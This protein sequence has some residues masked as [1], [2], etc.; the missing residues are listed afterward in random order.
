MSYRRMIQSV[1]THSGEPMRVITGGVPHIPGDSV[2]EQAKWLERHDDQLRLMMLREPRGYPPLCCNLLVPPK[3]P[4]ADAGFIIMEQVEYPMMSGGNTIAVATVLLET[5]MIPMREPLTRFTLEAPAGLIDITAECRGG[6]VL[7]V[8]FENVPAFCAYRDAVL[9]VPELGRVTVDVAWGGMFYVIADVAQF[10]GL[11]LEP[12]RGRDITRVC[13]LVLGAAQQQLPVE[14]PDYPG[15]GITIAQLSGAT[16]GPGADLR[17]AVTV[18]SGPVD[19]ADPAT[20]TGG[21]DRC[22]CGTGT[23]AKMAALHAKGEL[24]LHQPF[25]H[26]GVLGN[27]YTGELVREVRLGDRAAVVPTISG[28]AWITGF[29]TWVLEADD[30]YPNGFTVG[31]IW[32][33]QDQPG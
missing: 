30:P 24:R 22:P 10:A 9:D 20:W 3:H 31:D 27:V 19:L 8:T 1:E 4:D 15:I 12:G 28:R 14:H 11:H 5:G 13:A 16:T 25:R 6:R 29:C 7:G 26:E 17:N 33:A 32:A 23:C 2:Y 21:I 18:A